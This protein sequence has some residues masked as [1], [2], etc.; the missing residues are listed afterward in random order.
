MNKWKH[1]NTK[2]I[3]II[4]TKYDLIFGLGDDMN[5]YVWDYSNGGWEKRWN[6]E[7]K[8]EEQS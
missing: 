3:Q 1:P 4:C 5:M 8:S 6:Y 2:I 7:D